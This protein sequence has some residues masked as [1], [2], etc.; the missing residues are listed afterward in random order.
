MKATRHRMWKSSFGLL[1]L[2]LV[3]ASGSDKPA[4]AVVPF[5]LLKTKHI[6]V[7]IKING[8]GPYRVIFDTGAP[9]MLVNTKVARESGLMAKSSKPSI[10]SPFGSMGQMT[11]HSLEL[12]DL[13]AENVATVVMDHPTVELISKLLGPIEG[14]VGFPFFARYRTTIDYQAKQLT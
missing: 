9:V 14:I 10:F 13:K 2:A 11:I 6:V 8:K 4:A 1:A 7:P 3:S 12:G 5:D